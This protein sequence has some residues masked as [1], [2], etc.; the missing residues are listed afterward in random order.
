MSQRNEVPV[1]RLATLLLLLII[2]VAVNA[3]EYT[4]VGHQSVEVDEAALTA[5]FDVAAELIDG[6]IINNRLYLL[7][8]RERGGELEFWHSSVEL[9]AEPGWVVFLDENPWAEWEHPTRC[10]YI[11]IDGEVTTFDV[12]TPPRRFDEMVE[13]SDGSVYE[14][15]EEY[16]VPDL[17]YY[18]ELGERFR[19]QHPELLDRAGTHY[20]LMLSG[21]A[22][23]G[24]NHVRYYNNIAFAYTNLVWVYGYSE[25]N[26]YVLMSDGDDPA[27]DRTDGSS[28]PTDLDGDG[29]SDYTDPCT[30]SYVDQYFDMLAGLVTADDTFY[31]YTTDHGGGGGTTAYLNLWN[32]QRYYDYEMYNKLAAMDYDTILV[33]MGQCH[34]GGFVDNLDDLPNLVISTA[35]SAGELSYAFEDYT[36]YL[37]HWT[38]AVNNEYPGWP[39]EYNGGAPVDADDNADGL[40]SALEAF[41]YADSVYHYS[42]P[43]YADPSG[44]GEYLTLWGYFLDGPFVVMEDYQVEADDGDSSIT[45]GDQAEIDLT[46]HNL[47]GGQADNITATLSSNDSEITVITDTI[48]F[49]SLGPDSTGDSP[50]PFVIEA[51]TGADNPSYYFLDCTVT[52]DDDMDKEYELVVT[53]GEYDGDF[54]DDIESGDNGWAAE[55]PGDS[56][57]HIED[58]RS[59]SPSHSWKCGGDDGG[60]YANNAEDALLSPLVIVNPADPQLTF[61]TYHDIRVNDTVEVQW[62]NEYD[63]WET[64]ATFTDAMVDWTEANYDFSAYAGAIGRVRFLMT[65]N[66]GNT[67]EGFY[68]DD[69]QLGTPNMDLEV[70]AFNAASTEEGLLLNWRIE[71]A[72]GILALDVLREDSRGII[73]I[74]ERSLEP[75]EAGAYLDRDAAAGESSDYYL[76]ITENDGGMQLYGPLSAVYELPST[77]VFNLAAPYPCPSAGSLT[78]EFELAEDSQITLSVYD[79]SGRRV[80]ALVDGSLSAGRHSVEWDAAAQTEG[81]YFLRLTT[82]AGSLT[83]RAVISR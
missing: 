12:T 74:N 19:A 62:G 58:Y 69:F 1:K 7:P 43:Q 42:T 41:N 63:G 3:A 83:R 60:Y 61:M 11:T 64:I 25:D 6:D 8:E 75:N 17:D 9:P 33:T 40:I 50:T 21:G 34:S 53:V 4:T 39:V 49:G 24:N 36:Y 55:D 46:L 76:R 27:P 56:E 26:I 54:Q 28:T 72:S 81:V 16:W 2:P 59:Y 10:A 18:R 70:A 23:S 52:A 48:N 45:P 82:P 79:L 73:Q 80:A 66:A 35:C 44:I 30:H 65:T 32:L 67:G 47:G 13:L 29:D 15:S 71:D 57:W 38:A 51:S 68:F 37:L 20:A 5:A 22:D 14:A 77:R 78:I 31:I